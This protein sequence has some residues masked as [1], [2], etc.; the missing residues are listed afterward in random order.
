MFV[1]LRRQKYIKFLAQGSKYS[2]NQ[3]K[4]RQNGHPQV[5][6]I[7]RKNGGSKRKGK[8]RR[9]KSEEKSFFG[10]AL[11]PTIQLNGFAPKPF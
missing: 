1:L 11:W 8:K 10:Y 4:T 3:A 9:K 5:P 6:K 7:A 2:R